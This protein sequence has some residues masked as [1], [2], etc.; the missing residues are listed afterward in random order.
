M[1][2]DQ[3]A[4]ILAIRQASDVYH[5]SPMLYHQK[6]NARQRLLHLMCLYEFMYDED[7]HRFRRWWV[8]PIFTA[9]Q[10]LNQRFS[11]NLVEVLKDTNPALYFNFLRMSH[12]TF[13]KLLRMVNPLL[14][15]EHVVRE[16]ISS[17]IKLQLVLR[18]LASE[19]S[20]KSISYAFRVS[21]SSVC[22]FVEDVCDALYTVLKDEVLQIPTEEEWLEIF[23]EYEQLTG[24]T[25]C[26]GGLDGKLVVM[27]A[28]PHSG[29]D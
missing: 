1:D 18:Y 11:D 2:E 21:P 10:R 15:K 24:F 12:A 3:A 4:L 29:S 17:K 13:E 25:H 20:Q 23:E 14:E 16:P 8:Q 28:P 27:E 5:N 7:D 19:D 26:C 6:E 22:H 9:E